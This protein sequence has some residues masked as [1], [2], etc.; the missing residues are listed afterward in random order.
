MNLRD[1]YNKIASDWH[2]DHLSDD[3]W[4]DG[5]NAFATFLPHGGKVLD[6]GCAGEVKS[7][8]FVE[9][10][11]DVVGID[12]A[13]NF[14]DIAKKEVPGA[15]FYVVDIRENNYPE[16]K[17]DG[18]FIQAVLLHIPKNETRGILKKLMGL[19]NPNGLIYVAV[20][21]PRE[22][23]AEE[24]MLREDDYGYEYER[25]FSYYTQEELEDMFQS[26][27]M[28]VTLSE[29]IMSGKTRWVQVIA[30]KK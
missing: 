4:K 25:F 8:A 3:W 22:G 21:E 12:F 7:K 23:Q 15:S 18:I 2:K 28:K 9:R 13:S 30:Q 6:V 20:K 19:L 16:M 10:G 14:I 27:G 5:F 17:F 26:L 11:F 1:T 24:E 29:I